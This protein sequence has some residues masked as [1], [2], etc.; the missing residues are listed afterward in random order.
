MT[1]GVLGHGDVLL[2]SGPTQPERGREEYL[3]LKEARQPGIEPNPKRKGVSAVNKF[4]GFLK[5]GIVCIINNG[6]SPNIF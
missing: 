2:N 3:Y 5:A 6:K 4:H 1:P